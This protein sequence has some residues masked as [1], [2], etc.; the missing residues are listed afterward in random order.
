ML[1]HR[2]QVLEVEQQQPVV[3]GD[4]EHECE[5]ARCVSFRLS[6][7]PSSSGPMSEIVARTG[8]P[9]WPNTIPEHDRAR[10]N[11]GVGSLSASRRSAIFGELGPAAGEPGEIAFYVGH[12]HRHADC[13]EALGQYLQ[14]DGLAGPVAPVIRP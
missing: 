7:R 6:M 5:H 9:L 14:G 12:E 4:L 10:P 3:V 8:W 13:R 11:S 1:Q 2:A